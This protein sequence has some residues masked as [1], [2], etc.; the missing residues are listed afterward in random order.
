LLT[1]D[2]AD[3]TPP[4]EQ[5]R[6]Q[7]VERIRDGT[8]PA[9]TRLPTVRGLAAELGL[10]PNTVARAYRELETAGLVATRGRGGT[11]VLADTPVLGRLVDAARTFAATVHELGVA[12]AEA[13][14]VVGGVLQPDAAWDPAPLTATDDPEGRSGRDDRRAGEGVGPGPAR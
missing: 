7:L 1:L 5:V 6:R 11:V 8:L 4:F 14:R 10:A 9:G 13:L 12:P 2:A 3:A